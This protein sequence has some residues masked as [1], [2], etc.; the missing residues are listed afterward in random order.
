MGKVSS[1][2]G[3]SLSYYSQPGAADGQGLGHTQESAVW[4][5]RPVKS[6]L[7]MH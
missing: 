4:H 1:S 6:S 5:A 2:F 7:T 3:E